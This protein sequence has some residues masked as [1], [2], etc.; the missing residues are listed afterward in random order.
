MKLGD[1]LRISF[2]Q[3]ENTEIIQPD[4]RILSSSKGRNLRNSK[5]P[6]LIDL[7]NLSELK[8]FK[9]WLIATERF[10]PEINKNKL[11]RKVEGRSPLDQTQIG[12]WLKIISIQHNNNIV[13]NI[14]NITK[15]RANLCKIEKLLSDSSKL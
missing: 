15:S 7:W 3:E 14:N 8:G 12:G 6:S 2:R 9:G 4:I 11:D 13:N 5:S 10:C 1:Q